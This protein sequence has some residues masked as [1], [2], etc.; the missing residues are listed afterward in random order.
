MKVLVGC[1][2]CICA[3]CV[4]ACNSSGSGKVRSARRRR[5]VTAQA[6]ISCLVKHA[7][8]SRFH[9]VTALAEAENNSSMN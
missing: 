2:D 7:E 4:F 9:S 3:E 6:V 1:A 8:R 5:D